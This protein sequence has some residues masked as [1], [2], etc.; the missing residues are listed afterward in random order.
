MRQPTDPSIRAE[1]R[2]PDGLL[3]AGGQLATGQVVDVRLHGLRIEAVGAPGT[4]PPAAERL[5]LSGYLLLPAPAEPH[6]HFDTA[7]TAD[8]IPNPAGDLAG[9]VQAWLYYQG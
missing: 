6:A 8:Q 3:L 7:L 5:D 1:P 9:A 2:G 4:L